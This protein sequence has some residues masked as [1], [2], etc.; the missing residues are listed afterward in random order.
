MVS[1]NAAAWR[2][3]NER[4]RDDHRHPTATTTTAG[5][6][7][8]VGEACEAIASEKNPPDTCRK[9]AFFFMSAFPTYVCPEP[10]LAKLSF[11]V[12]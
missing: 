4:L 2:H 11:L 5:I 1:R 9:N 8:V 10:V 6:A 3:Q 7:V 12:S